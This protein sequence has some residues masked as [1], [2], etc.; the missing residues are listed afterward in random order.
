MFLSWALVSTLLFQALI[1]S[2]TTILNGNDP[3]LDPPHIKVGRLVFY[4]IDS[5]RAWLAAARETTLA[6]VQRA[7]PSGILDA[8]E[9]FT[10]DRWDLDQADE[11][12]QISAGSLERQ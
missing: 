8:I 11:S 12:D 2:G 3:R 10:A 5:V 4:R 7:L 6:R 1:R 9:V